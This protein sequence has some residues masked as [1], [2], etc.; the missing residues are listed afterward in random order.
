LV[1]RD[2]RWSERADVDEERLNILCAVVSH[3]HSLLRSRPAAW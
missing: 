2:R 3:R 1:G